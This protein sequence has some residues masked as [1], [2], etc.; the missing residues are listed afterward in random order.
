MA[1]Y[2][3]SVD[4]KHLVMEAGGVDRDALLA[5]P[6]IDIISSHLYEYWARVKGEPWE[7]AP[8]AK[9]EM[10]GVRGKKPLIVDELGL[11]TY[12]N[13]RALLETIREEGIVGGLLWGIR[14]HRR[15]GGWYY[16]NEGGTFVN[17][18]HIPGFAA[19]YSFEEIRTL[20]LLRKEA[21]AIR[22]EAIPAIKAPTGI[23]ELMV[24]E[25]GFTWKGCAGANAYTIERAASAD[26]PWTIMVTGIHDSV[27]ADV[28]AHEGAKIYAPTV[29]WHDEYADP[30]KTWYYRIKGYNVTGETPYSPVLRVPAK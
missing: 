7:L 24:L 18:Y 6:N 12:D 27:I 13:L 21:Y 19:G 10:A 30:A 20:D 3:K 1:A 28:K 25:K 11:A 29:L 14:G 8:M 9:H 23:P 5:D 22:G 16:H 26:G 2:I 17:S 15:D 4:P